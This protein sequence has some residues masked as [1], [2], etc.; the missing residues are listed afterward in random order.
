MRESLQNLRFW[1]WAGVGT[2]ALAIGLDE[3]AA[4]VTWGAA[5]LGTVPIVERDTLRVN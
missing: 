5:K 2:V 1:T 4:T 3:S